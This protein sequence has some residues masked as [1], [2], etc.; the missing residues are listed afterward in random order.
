MWRCGYVAML[1][2]GYMGMWLRDC[3]AMRLCGQAS[4]LC[5]AMRLLMW[6]CGYVAMWL[7]GYVATYYHTLAVPAGNRWTKV[8][9]RDSYSA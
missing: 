8:V 5:V 2:C 6:L 4:W 3:V 7:C 1:L 9:R